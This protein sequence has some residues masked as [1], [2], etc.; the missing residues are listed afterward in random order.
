VEDGQATNA[1]K[2]QTRTGKKQKPKDRDETKELSHQGTDAGDPSIYPTK[3][4]PITH[5]SRPTGNRQ[6]G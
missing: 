2:K 4:Q 5:T 3:M 1:K 6:G